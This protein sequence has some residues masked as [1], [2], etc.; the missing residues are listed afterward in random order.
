MHITKPTNAKVDEQTKRITIHCLKCL[1]RRFKTRSSR[2]LTTGTMRGGGNTSTSTSKES[3]MSTQTTVNC[4]VYILQVG[5]ALEL[6]QRG[7]GSSSAGSRNH[8]PIIHWTFACLKTPNS[9]RTRFSFVE[10][11]ITT[12]GQ[13]LP[14]SATIE[15]HACC[16]HTIISGCTTPSTSVWVH[17]QWTARCIGNAIVRA[18]A[19]ENRARWPRRWP[20]RRWGRRRRR[21]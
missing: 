6:G 17:K 20:R 9:R 1:T 4:L 8:C 16:R 11:K 18:I 2:W 3:G 15:N 12:V 14:A 13:C 21:R 5:L 19:T 7:S 10:A